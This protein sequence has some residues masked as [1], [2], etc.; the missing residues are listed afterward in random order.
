MMKRKGVKLYDLQLQTE[1]RQE[2]E[3]M[4][5]PRD[6]NRKSSY[7]ASYNNKVD[8]IRDEGEG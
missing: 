5:N 7:D 8:T 2:K 3:K 1:N 6:E 4:T